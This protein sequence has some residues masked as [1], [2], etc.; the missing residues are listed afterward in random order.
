MSNILQF[1]HLHSLVYFIADKPTKDNVSQQ[2]PLVGT[3]S[4]RTL[5]EW[6]GM[7]DIDITRVR[8][9]NQIDGPFNNVMSRM[10]LNRAIE[11]RQI[12]VVAL[13]QKAATY[14]RKAGITNYFMLPHPSGR[15]RLLND[16]KFVKVKLDLCKRFIYEGVNDE[17]QPTQKNSGTE[18]SGYFTDC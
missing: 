6:I 5:L 12:C 10:S 4:Y 13:G 14:L 8:L 18:S 17:R 15:N 3:S 11:L 16:K 2:I 7:M 9:Y 1:P